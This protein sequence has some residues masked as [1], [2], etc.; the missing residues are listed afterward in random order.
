MLNFILC[1]DD[2]KFLEVMKNDIRKFMMNYNTSYNIYSFDCY[3]HDFNG[4]TTADIG[5]KVYF[6]DIRTGNASGIDAARLIREKVEDWNSLIVIVTAYDE[7]RYTAL[8]NRLFLLDFISKCGG[9]DDKILSILKII[10][11]HYDT[12]EKCLTYEYNYMLHKI[13]FRKIVYIEKEQE[14]KRSIVYTTY[15]TF[16]VP[17]SIVELE[18]T[19]DKRFLKV[20][21]GF[22]V[23]L[24]MVRTFD[25][26]S[27]V[28]YF[29]NGMKLD[30]V[31]RNHKKE[32]M[33]KCHC[34]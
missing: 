7:Y 24:N 10:M 5:Y 6:L 4:I 3:D 17:K 33:E 34:C 22:L 15:G 2:E 28:I 13:E 30:A 18:K 21:R 29:S 20:H 11:K 27:N 26:K 16:K 23:N 1:D 8:T 31:A 9:I 19:L 12:R 25:V 32:L 14:S